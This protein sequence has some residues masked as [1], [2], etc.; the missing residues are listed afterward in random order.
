[1]V[2][3]TLARTEVPVA[4]IVPVV[5]PVLAVKVPA[6]TLVAVAFARA[7]NPDTLIVPVVTPVLAITTPADTLVAVT[8][9]KLDKLVAL[10]VPAEILVFNIFVLVIFTVVKVPAT[11]KLPDKLKFAPVIVVAD[12]VPALIELPTTLVADKAP[13]VILAKLDKPDAFIVPA[14]SKLAV[15]LVVL[16]PK[17]PFVKYEVELICEN[18][19]DAAVFKPIYIIYKY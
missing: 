7:D 13:V 8:F 6:D 14:T 3:V 11:L 12:K 17:F 18:E 16:I 5:I 9:C 15:G 19:I 10:I 2:A 1:M 4:L